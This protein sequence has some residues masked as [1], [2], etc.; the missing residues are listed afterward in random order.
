MLP[1]LFQRHILKRLLLSFSFILG[2]LFVTYALLHYSTHTHKFLS[3]GT[4]TLGKIL[5]F[6]GYEFIRRA[7]FLLPFAFLIALL[8][9]LLRMNTSRELLALLSSGIS[10]RSILR[11]IWLSSAVIAS[12]ILINHQFS[13]PFACAK[14]EAFRIINLKGHHKSSSSSPFQ[15][16]YL[17]DGSRLFY[18]SYDATYSSYSDVLWLKSFDELWHIKTLCM[19]QHKCQGY[20]IDI[21]TRGVS[22]NIEK[23]ESHPSLDMSFLALEKAKKHIVSISV[24]AQP[25][26]YLIVHLSSANSQYSTPEIQSELMYK[27][28][29]VLLP[30]VVVL[31]I[32][33]ITLN[34]QRRSPLFLLYAL[35]IFSFFAFMAALDALKILSSNHTL[36]VWSALFFPF[37]LICTLLAGQFR[38]KLR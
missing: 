37:L 27:F 14:Q 8:F 5:E 31:G 11:P 19:S 33:P 38:F 3:S 32:V 4:M 34:Y 13:L 16:L 10:L 7:S 24:D 22:G 2:V 26:S 6:Y 25:L 23:K 35:S 15:T 36:S 30:L 18:Q 20:Y 1:L 28:L 9:T 21:L 12:L 29:L 17:K